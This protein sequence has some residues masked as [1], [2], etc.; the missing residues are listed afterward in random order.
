[1]YLLESTLQ[2]KRSVSQSRNWEHGNSGA[3][4]EKCSVKKFITP[5]DNTFYYL[6]ARFFCSMS[7]FSFVY[8]R[9]VGIFSLKGFSAA[10]ISTLLKHD[11]KFNNL[12][13]AKLS[14]LCKFLSYL[15]R[16]SDFP[17]FPVTSIMASRFRQYWYAPK[18]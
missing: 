9:R 2:R 4:A 7:Y 11:Q 17:I 8:L 12:V 10:D 16:K 1:M 18:R 15:A 5:L 14:S 6:S 3:S 13:A